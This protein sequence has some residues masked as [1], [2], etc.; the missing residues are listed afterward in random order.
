MNLHELPMII[1]TVASQM[2][3]GMFVVLGIVDLW[4][5]TKVDNKTADRLVTPIVY[6]IGP[7]LVI[8][9]ITSM[10]H[11]NDISNM[12]NVI[13]N[14]ASSWLSREIL[15]VVAFAGLGALYAVMQWFSAG[16]RRLRQ[17]VAFAAAVVGLFLV[18]C[19]SM[20]YA[21]VE[22]IP[23]WNTWVV[24]FQFFMTTL[25]LGAAGVSTSLAVMTVIRKRSERKAQALA[26]TRDRSMVSDRVAA[27]SGQGG[28]AVD[29]RPE[30]N[31]TERKRPL[32]SADPNA[33]HTW[34]DRLGFTHNVRAIQAKPTTEE[35]DY[36]TK[37]IRTSAVLSAL[38]A[39]AILI[40]YVVHIQNLAMHQSPAA[41]AA[42][43][44]FSGGFFWVRLILLGIGAVAV[45]FVSFRLANVDGLGNPTPLATTAVLGL[46]VLIA[47]EFMG[48]SL[49]YD[50]MF[51][52]GIG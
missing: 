30:P 24:P 42:V 29:E 4:L 48:R 22:T 20:I 19:E 26:G 43:A 37:I 23:A 45:A 35:W 8:A 21:S 28:V 27:G 16:N 25:M 38:A 2:A 11:M 3:V 49:H 46:I 7:V 51:L 18:L 39:V 32:N 50:T 1:F 36:T 14:W 41:T 9:M 6:L 31:R 15:S 44:V 5:S 10:F 17:L 12:F 40:S 47:A 52:V 34:K 33:G 13:R